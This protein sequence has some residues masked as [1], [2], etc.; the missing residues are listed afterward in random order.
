L[1]EGFF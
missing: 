1:Q